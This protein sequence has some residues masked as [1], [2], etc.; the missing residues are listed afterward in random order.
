MFSKRALR[1]HHRSRVLTKAKRLTRRWHWQNHPVL[2]ATENPDESFTE[3]RAVRMAD[4]LKVCSLA[5]HGCGNRRHGGYEQPLTLQELKHCL[6]Y[7]EELNELFCATP[8]DFDL[9]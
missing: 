9:D 1:R 2:K 5:R 7:E 4:N 6:S 8:V 3:D